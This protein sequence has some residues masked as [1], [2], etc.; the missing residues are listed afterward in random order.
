MQMCSVVTYACAE[1][2]TVAHLHADARLT[3][4][5]RARTSCLLAHNVV[6]LLLSVLRGVRL[7]GR[8]VLGAVLFAVGALRD[9]R[10][11]LRLAQTQTAS[12]ELALEVQLTRVD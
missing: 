6:G 7:E 4:L 8:G 10:V 12:H 9:E 3:A 1:A 11:V 5:Q 2:R